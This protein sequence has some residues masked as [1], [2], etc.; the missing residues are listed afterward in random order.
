MTAQASYATRDV[1]TAACS[2]LLGNGYAVAAELGIGCYEHSESSPAS[3]SGAQRRM[4]VVGLKPNGELIGI[5]VKSSRS[6]LLTDRKLRFYTKW[7]DRLYIAVPEPLLNDAK[8]SGYLDGIGLL[9]I[10]PDRY[11]SELVCE[12]ARRAKSY[13]ISVP[14]RAA[15]IMAIALRAG[16]PDFCPRCGHRSSQKPLAA[17]HDANTDEV[18]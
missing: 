10:K 17:L 16:S 13:H 15:L 7:V 5:E 9:C 14:A 1:T 4:D 3:C 12:I 18:G 11:S 2:W 6:D 8:M